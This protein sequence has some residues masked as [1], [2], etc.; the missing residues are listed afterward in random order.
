MKQLLKI[1]GLCTVTLIVLFISY[2][3]YN[4]VQRDKIRNIKINVNRSVLKKI[5]PIHPY[6]FCKHSAKYQYVIFYD[7][8]H[9]TQCTINRLYEWNSLIEMTIQ[10]KVPIDFIFIFEAKGDNINKIIRLFHQSHFMHPIYIDSI[11]YYVRENPLAN[12]TMYHAVITD[13]NG[14]IKMIGN[15]ATSTIS[16]NNF[17]KFLNL[18][19]QRYKL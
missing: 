13:N 9:C 19:K 16:T 11:G 6:P 12:N 10:R 14:Y 4:E 18:E 1:T 3:C 17:K 8:L 7:S 2:Y 5:E 15:A